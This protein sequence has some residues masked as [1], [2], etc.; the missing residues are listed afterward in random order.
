MAFQ[1]GLVYSAASIFK[2][3]GESAQAVMLRGAEGATARKRSGKRTA[4]LFDEHVCRVATPAYPLPLFSVG[5]G[6]TTCVSRW[7]VRE[8]RHA[9]EQIGSG[10]RPD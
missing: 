2:T 7:G 1:R 6:G 5:E 8:R 4:V 10:E 9:K 3:A